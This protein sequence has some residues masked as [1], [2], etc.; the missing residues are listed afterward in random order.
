[1]KKIALLFQSGALCVVLACLT[2]ATAPLH[3]QAPAENAAARPPT[4][5]ELSQTELLKS[6]LQVREQLHAALLA[7]IN[8]RVEAEAA[9][10]AQAAAVGEKLEGIRAAIQ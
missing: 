10:R 9:A 3:A 4:A 7:I 6:Y 1:M 2:I 5:D 8:N